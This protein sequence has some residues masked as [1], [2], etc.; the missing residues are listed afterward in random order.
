MEPD[1]AAVPERR[2]AA[3]GPRTF[4]AER[5]TVP[6]GPARPGDGSTE[7]TACGGDQQICCPGNQCR[8]NGCCVAGR[9]VS[10]F[11]TCLPGRTCVG[12]GSCGGCG[13]PPHDG[14]LENCCEQQICTASKTTCAGLGLGKCQSCGGGGQ[15][16]CRD[17]YCDTGFVC[18]SASGRCASCGLPDQPCCADQRC[19][20]NGCCSGNLCVDN[21]GTCPMGGGL[22][23]SGACANCGT[24][25][26][27]CCPGQD[28]GKSCGA[29]DTVCVM[30]GSPAVLQCVAC[31]GTTQPCC[32]DKRCTP[33]GACNAMNTCELCGAAGQLC[34]AGDLCGAGGCCINGRCLAAGTSCGAPVGNCV[35][36]RCA[37]CGDAGQ[38]CCPTA[39]S[40][41]RTACHTNL[42]C[43]TN[44]C[45]P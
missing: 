41:T 44:T 26:K 20:G 2:D 17:G 5:D 13:G 7:T 6:D 35:A 27:K 22:C 1:G 12:G 39:A 19:S 37:G 33:G 40:A 10:A 8:D 31:G 36:G 15:L 30:S 38:P 11:T 25:G 24:E 18:D 3:D 21:G 29:K 32:P 45:I 28:A 16:C 14:V 4:D 43:S 23:A 34:C 9:C 42:T